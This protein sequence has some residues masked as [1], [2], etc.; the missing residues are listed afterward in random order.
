[1]KACRLHKG[2]LFYNSEAMKNKKVT[3]LLIAVVLGV[4]GLILYR[5]FDAVGNNNDIPPVA[6]MRQVK[7]EYNDFSLPK[8]TAKLKL[9]Y[10]D[11]F[12][13]AKPKD[14][15]SKR[16]AV[17]IKQPIKTNVKPSINWGFISYAGYVRNPASKK[18]VTL[19]LI[20]G[21]NVTLS[22]GETREQVKLLRNLRDSVKV[23][24]QGKTKFIT[25]KS[26]TL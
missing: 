19:L 9:N 1:M 13:L 24:Y 6:N 7:E 26:T 22:E 16:T 4:W 3:Y 5:L 20:N 23:S 18:L 2:L 10:R 21:K 17:S 15:T 8:D 14:T 12:G 25:L 11:P